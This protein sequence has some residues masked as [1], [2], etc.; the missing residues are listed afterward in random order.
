MEQL[1][2]L[3]IENDP[4][5][6]FK[7][8]MVSFRVFTNLFLNATICRDFRWCSWKEV[9]KCARQSKKELD[10]SCM[11]FIIEMSDCNIVKYTEIEK[12]AASIQDLATIFN[13]L[14]LLVVVQVCYSFNFML[15]RFTFCVRARKTGNY[16]R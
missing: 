15:L 16:F 12:L 10:V 9:K 6:H 3:D 7:D 8:D 2:D 13:Q 4:D 5:A 1:I 11:S 14:S